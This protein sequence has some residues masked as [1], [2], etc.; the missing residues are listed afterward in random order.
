[1][2]PPSLLSIPE[3]TRI[4]LLGRHNTAHYKHRVFEEGIGLQDACI[5]VNVISVVD[6]HVAGRL[7]RGIRV[8][9][10]ASAN[11]KKTGRQLTN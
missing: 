3:N 1:M 9:E 5:S 8:P 11:V 2:A 4:S 7:Q 6:T 10:G